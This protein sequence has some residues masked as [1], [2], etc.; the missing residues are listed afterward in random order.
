MRPPRATF[1]AVLCAWDVV[2]ELEDRGESQ[3]SID[4]ARAYAVSKYLGI[5]PSDLPRIMEACKALSTP[6]GSLTFF[7]PHAPS[8]IEPPHA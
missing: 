7:L 2:Q 8:F 1:D 4:S 3:E 6:G 5:R